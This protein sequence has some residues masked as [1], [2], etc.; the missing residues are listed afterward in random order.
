MIL[1]IQ[2]GVHMD[3]PIY[4]LMFSTQIHIIKLTNNIFQEF[5]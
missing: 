2:F 3:M 1:K 4:T 5:K